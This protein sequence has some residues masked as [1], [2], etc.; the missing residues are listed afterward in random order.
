MAEPQLPL[1]R[2]IDILA[3][4]ARDLRELLDSGKCTSVDLVQLYLNQ[5]AKHNHDGMK[6]HAI[7]AIATALKDAG[8]VVIALANLSVRFALVRFE[9]PR[10][11]TMK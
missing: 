2:S 4:T 3:A 5:I 11:L 9:E 7:N 6:L 10:G 1:E 8:C